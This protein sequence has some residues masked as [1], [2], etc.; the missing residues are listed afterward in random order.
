M[1]DAS[2]TQSERRCWLFH[3][4]GAEYRYFSVETMK[5]ETVWRRRVPDVWVPSAEGGGLG[6]P[7]AKVCA[8]CGKRKLLRW[9]QGG[10]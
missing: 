10:L 2:S 5:Y 8:R 1:A 4:W 9:A 7:D 6:R 3:D